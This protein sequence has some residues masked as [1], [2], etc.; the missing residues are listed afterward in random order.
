MDI[1]IPQTTDLEG[2]ITEF[3]EFFDKRKLYLNPEDI[4][5]TLLN[6]CDIVQDK[7]RSFMKLSS[8]LPTHLRY[9][10][11]I[12]RA[13]KNGRVEIYRVKNTHGYK[14]KLVRLGQVI[15]E[16]GNVLS[17]KELAQH[18]GYRVNKRV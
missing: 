11:T 3:Y 16:N 18:P 13:G 7:P 1:N 15:D 5:G 8:A 9:V 12:F 17:H 4:H 14:I 6:K 10:G 2:T